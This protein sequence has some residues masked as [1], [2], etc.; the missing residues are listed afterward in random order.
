L[1]GLIAKKSPNVAAIAQ[2]FEVLQRSLDIMTKAAE[3]KIQ[4]QW[5]ES[6]KQMRIGVRDRNKKHKLQK[7]LFCDT[8]RLAVNVSTYV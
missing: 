7:L 6:S 3:T 2:E 5:K 1:K 8:G 4:K